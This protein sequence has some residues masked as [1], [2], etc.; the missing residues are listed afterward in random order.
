MKTQLLPLVVSKYISQGQVLVVCLTSFHIG[1]Y[2]VIAFRAMYNANHHYDILMLSLFSNKLLVIIFLLC[3]LEIAGT[4]FSCGM[5][6]MKKRRLL[7]GYSGNW[8]ISY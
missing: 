4:N 6:L 5:M 1:K 2:L 7:T 3:L 8:S